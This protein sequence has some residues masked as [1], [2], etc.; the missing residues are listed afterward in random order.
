M[1]KDPWQEEQLREERS[2]EEQSAIA[3]ERE[4]EAS[5]ERLELAAAPFGPSEEELQR[6]V[7][8][9]LRHPDLRNVLEE[10]E[11]RVI[12]FNAIADCGCSRRF[13]L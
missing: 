11:H 8:G 6:A 3:D 7:E 13:V 1:E 5:N 2:A 4:D 10:A 9:L 12:S